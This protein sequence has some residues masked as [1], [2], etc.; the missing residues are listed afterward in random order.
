[1]S[2]HTAALNWSRR[3]RDFT[4]ETYSR[5]H[6][7]TFENGQ[8][9][10]ASSAPAFVGNPEAL[11]PE[12]LLVGALAS[13]HLLTFLAVCAKRGYVVESYDDAASGVLGKNAEGKMAITRITLRPRVAFGGDKVPSPEEL[14]KLHERAHANCFIGSS[15]RSEVT[16]EPA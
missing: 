8:K 6:V 5:D 3:G 10:L 13:C 14:A 16:V 15:T 2:E 1:M 7:V 12:T 9:A 4:Y 11:N